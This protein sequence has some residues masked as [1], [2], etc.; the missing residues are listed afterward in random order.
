LTLVLQVGWDAKEGESHTDKL[1]RASVMELLDSFAW[2]DQAVAEE[3]KRRFD[4]HWEDPSVLP[5][6]YKVHS[7]QP[8]VRPGTN[9][10]TRHV[11]HRKRC[12]RSC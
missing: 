11:N 8:L 9:S 6:E 1:M 7:Q 5:T 10:A 12:T 4:A 3:A 2:D